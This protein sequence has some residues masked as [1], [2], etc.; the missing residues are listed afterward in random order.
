MA[1]TI[2]LKNGS[3]APA[4]SDLVQGEPAIDLT[5]KRLYTENASGAIIEVGSNPSSLSINGTA[6]TATAAEIN[7]LDGITSSTAELNILDGVTSTAAELNILDGVTST[8]AELNI[9][10]GVTS[11]ATELNILDGVTS[12]TAELNILDG[13]TS[14]AAELNI[15]DG[16][17]STT[18]ELNILDGVT[19]STAELN[20]LDGVTS[21][22]AELNILDGVTSTATELNVLDGVTAFVDEDNMS[23]NSA[24]SI[25]SQQSV[26]TYVDAQVIAGSGISDVVQDTT[27]QLGGDLDVNGKAIVSVSNGNIALT[28]N[29]S[30]VVRLDGNVDIQSGEIALKNAGSVSNIKLYCESSN[31]HYTQLQS[32]A[33]SAYSGNVT[34]TLPASTDTLVGKATT[35]T[36][37]N[38]TLTSPDIN[39]PDIDGGT[40]DGTVIGGSSAAA[41]TFSAL[42]ANSLTYPTSDGSNGQAIVTNGSGTLSFA[43]ISGGGGGITYVTKTANYT[44]SAGEGVIA[45]TAGGTF[46]I[47]LPASPSTGDQVIIADGNAWATT[48]LTVGRNSSTIEGVAADL[49]MDVSGISVTMV[50][51]GSTWQLYPQTGTSPS[52]GIDD[53]ATSTAIT[54]EADGDVGIGTASPQEQ[55]HVYTTADTRIEAESTTGIAGF[56]ATNNQGSYAW[57]VDSTADKFHLYDFT[58]SANRLT[59]DGA[60]NVGI[61]TTSPAEDLNIVGTGGTAKIRFDGDSSN[62]QNNFIGITGY[63]DLIIASDEANSGSA[64]TIQFRIDASERM[65]IDSS[66]NVGIG[67]TATTIGKTTISLA[68]VAVT[69]DTDGATIGAGGIF[70]LLNSNGGTA[71]STTLLMGSTGSG[72]VGQIASAIGFSRESSSNWGTQLRFYVHPVST[73]DLDALEEAARIDSSGNLVIGSTSAA[74]G[75]TSK[76][77]IRPGGDNYYI[78]PTAS[79]SFNRTASDGEILLFY[80]NG[81]YVG[82]VSVT[83]STA[84]FNSISDYRLKENVVNLTGATDRLKQLPVHQFNFTATPDITVDGFLAHEV[85]DIVP[86]AVTG[87]KDAMKTEEYE[88]TPEVLDEDDNVVTQAVM[89]TREVPDYQG[90]DQSKLVPLLTAALQEA[91]TRI[92]TLEAEVAALQGAN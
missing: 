46:T 48:N 25:P 26:K 40:I 22:A 28:P 68:G 38:K 62:L 67:T 56:K 84:S 44:M 61:G 23:S 57:Y 92:E 1:T 42:V 4:A 80:R 81:T 36:L 19:S 78:K 60:G 85:A 75:S 14:T 64:S 17:T 66:G 7:T 77:V 55:L 41:G 90:I 83:S 63:D 51:D 88:V 74:W 91:V 10:D 32:A 73:S 45:N 2:K 11:T 30:G 49:V 33:H 29:G 59:L 47:T 15:L 79:A 39:T 3:G 50:Y 31:A 34:L 20:I 37:T 12:S 43:T 5:N 54:I 13:V 6:V 87:T 16:V 69:G 21:T 27:P 53:N 72:S 65:R 52:L 35:D 71:N 76:N 82:N 70:N 9:L 58:D 18:A 86:A 24:T 8:T 89:G